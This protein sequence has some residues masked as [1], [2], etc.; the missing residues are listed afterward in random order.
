MSRSAG[1]TFCQV[2]YSVVNHTDVV[3][4]NS[5]RQQT[6]GGRAWIF[7]VYARRE[8]KFKRQRRPNLGFSPRKCLNFGSRKWDF[9]RFPRDIS[10]NEY[11]GKSALVSCSF[12]PSLLKRDQWH[13][14]NNNIIKQQRKYWHKHTNIVRKMYQPSSRFNDKNTLFQEIRSIVFPHISAYVRIWTLRS[15]KLLWQT[16]KLNS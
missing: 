2:R 10:V 1:R 5:N 12:Y 3:L 7:K 14:Q 9:Q 13:H 15:C 11:V 6:R 4:S 8:E 16:E